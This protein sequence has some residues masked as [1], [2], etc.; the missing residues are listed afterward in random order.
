MSSSIVSL[1]KRRST[2]TVIR[3]EFD[4]L[5]YPLYW[6]YDILG[7]L[8]AMGEA[9]FIGAPRCT[10]ALELLAAKQ[11]PDGGFPAEARHYKITGKVELGADAVDWEARASASRT[12]G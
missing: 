5:H 8:K 1:F 6:H 3:G 11:L 2:G 7:G 12:R 10:A 9:G 4:Q